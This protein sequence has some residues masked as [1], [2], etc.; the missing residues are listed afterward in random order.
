MVKYSFILM[1]LL[2]VVCMAQFKISGRVINAADKKP[3]ANASVFLSNATVGGKTNDEGVF[4]LNNIRAGQYELVV[5]FVGYETYRQIVRGNN[6][7]INLPTI[8]MVAKTTELNV[9]NIRPDPEWERNYDNFKREFLG[10]SEIARQC[11]ILNPEMLDLEFDSKAFR[12]TASSYDFLEIENKALGYRIKY[13]LTKFV[14][15]GKTNMLYFEGSALFADMKGSKAKMRRWEKRRNQVYTGSSMHFLRS[16]IANIT[17]ENHF[18]VFR[19]IR[20]PNPAYNGLNHKY[21]NTLINR[22][23]NVENYIKRTDQKGLFAIKYDDCLYI[24]YNAKPSKNKNDGASLEI[25]QP[26]QPA[27]IIDFVDAYA[28]FDNNG[29]ITTPSAL[30]FEGKWGKSRTAEMLPVDFEP[31]KKK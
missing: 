21:F 13:L 20:T 5:S 7:G 2:P 3:V 9:V 26:A 6:A 4:L 12:L 10:D 30:V 29:V 19:L 8:E 18:E 23:L 22:P 1:L 14:K 24:E 25:E 15:D 11:K 17:K 16:V 28:L 27:S 31:A